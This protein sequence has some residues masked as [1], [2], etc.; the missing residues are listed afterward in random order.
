MGLRMFPDA[1]SHITEPVIQF[2]RNIE[3]VMVH[4]CTESDAFLR[5]SNHEFHRTTAY[6]VHS[7]QNS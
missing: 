3:Q 1:Y 2:P 5:I 7:P 4:R 6:L